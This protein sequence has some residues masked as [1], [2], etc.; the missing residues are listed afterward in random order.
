MHIDSFKILPW[1]S[2]QLQEF[3]YSL[4][5]LFFMLV[6]F[7]SLPKKEIVNQSQLFFNNIMKHKKVGLKIHCYLTS[8]W[9]WIIEVI[10]ICRICSCLSCIRICFRLGCVSALVF[11]CMVLLELEKYVLLFQLYDDFL[12]CHF[13][14]FSLIT[15]F[16]TSVCYS[17]VSNLRLY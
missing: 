8:Y 15:C 9:F 4:H 11:F 5:H 1:S 6:L 7:T 16:V 10:L 12:T 3:K 2:P 17:C 13:F 14:S